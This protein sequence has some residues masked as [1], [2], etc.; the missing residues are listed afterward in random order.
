MQGL[1]S[2]GELILLIVVVIAASLAWIFVL[3]YLQAVIDGWGLWILIVGLILGAGLVG[4]LVRFIRERG[5]ARPE[6]AQDPSST[7]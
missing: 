6:S 5:M 3:L 4:S 1:R 2:F 7:S